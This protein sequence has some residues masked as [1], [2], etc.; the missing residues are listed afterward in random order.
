MGRSLVRPTSILFGE[1]IT[2]STHNNSSPRSSRGIDK[3]VSHWLGEKQNMDTYN[4]LDQCREATLL[5]AILT[6]TTRRL[7]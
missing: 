2:K 3:S 7:A 4:R 5:W 6:A 1:D